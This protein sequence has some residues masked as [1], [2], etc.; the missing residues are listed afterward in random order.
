[1]TIFAI[2]SGA[3]EPPAPWRRYEGRKY[4]VQVQIPA[5]VTDKGVR[6]TD[7]ADKFIEEFNQQ[8]RAARADVHMKRASVNVTEAEKRRVKREN[9]RMMD[10]LIEQQAGMMAAAAGGGG[11]P[12]GWLPRAMAAYPPVDPRV[13]AV[14]D[15]PV[16]GTPF[17]K[18]IIRATQEV[19]TENA[20]LA[21]M[22]SGMTLN[23][24]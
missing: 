12:T 24:K 9:D 2:N 18:G 19:A 7:A 17:K 10:A 21:S 13:A 5:F 15:E 23:G 3:E 1:M 4:R 8:A 11:A 14:A 6:V 22:M 16:P 20:M